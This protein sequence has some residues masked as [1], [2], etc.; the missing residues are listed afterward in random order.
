MPAKRGDTR[1]KSKT[2]KPNKAARN[3]PSPAK[4]S[5]MY[6][7]PSQIRDR[8]AKQKLQEKAER[9]AKSQK[10][11]ARKTIQR[12]K[13]A[14]KN[15]KPS[16]KD[17]GKL[18][19]ISP[20][21]KRNPHQHGGKKSKDGKRTYDRKGYLVYVN[22]NGK[23]ELI[24]Q[25]RHGY[26]TSSF[27]NV[28]PPLASKYS[29]SRR[30]IYEARTARNKRGKAIVLGRGSIVPATKK[31]SFTD[32]V[33][34]KFS[35]AIQGQLDK[36]RGQKRFNIRVMIK[37]SGIDEPVIALIPIDKPDNA[38]IEKAG[39]RNFVKQKLYAHIS[40][41][42]AKAGFV[43]MG[44]SN[45]IRSLPWNDGKP[46]NKW[47]ARPGVK[48]DRWNKDIVTV[49]VFEWIFEKNKFTKAKS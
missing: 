47:E 10:R 13:L 17:A 28:Q 14:L 44:S 40:S 35:D 16:K 24:K 6:L 3:S 31:A 27:S 22:K 2:A 39:T 11:E 4:A 29:D 21:G 45:H 38:S 49:D 41:D 8:F 42:L 1:K 20:G 12:A 5:K 25:H 23:K 18:I 26:K 19:F 9:K 15:F 46:R 34:D 43:T 36:I 48:W 7:T 33:V 37:L 32:A 30:K